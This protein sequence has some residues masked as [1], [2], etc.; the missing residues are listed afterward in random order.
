MKDLSFNPVVVVP[1]LQERREAA[2]LAKVVVWLLNHPRVLPTYFW[3]ITAQP[4]EAM[5]IL[6]FEERF[7]L[8]L[9]YMALTAC[10]QAQ[11]REK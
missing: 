10:F 8:Q 6:P 9:T 5:A 11:R 1:K 2:V 4:S 7:N 3:M